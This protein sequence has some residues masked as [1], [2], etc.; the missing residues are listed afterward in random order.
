M[1]F[2]GVPSIAELNDEQATDLHQR[3]TALIQVGLAGPDPEPATR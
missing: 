1:A 3:L 2:Y